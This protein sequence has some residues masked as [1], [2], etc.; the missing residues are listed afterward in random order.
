MP[1]E[2]YNDWVDVALDETLHFGML[3]KRLQELGSHY[4]AWPT[5]DGAL[6]QD[7]TLLLVVR[8][9]GHNARAW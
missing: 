8:V 5:H 1:A 6:I 2:Y 7:R 3:S 4:G 9:P